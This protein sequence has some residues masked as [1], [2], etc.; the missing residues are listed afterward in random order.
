MDWCRGGVGG[1]GVL[2]H[3]PNVP[4]FSGLADAIYKIPREKKYKE[5]RTLGDARDGEAAGRWRRVDAG[6]QA[7]AHS[8]RRHFHG[9]VPMSICPSFTLATEMSVLSRSRESGDLAVGE[10]V[11]FGWRLG[12]PGMFCAAS[13]IMPAQTRGGAF[14]VRKQTEP[15]S[16]P[17]SVA[18]RLQTRSLISGCTWEAFSYDRRDR[19]RRTSAYLASRQ[20]SGHGQ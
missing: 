8:M 13:L 2:L 1:E 7:P 10:E 6:A 18:P 17:A 5:L 9:P 4:R 3:L 15:T 19:C 12:Q 16:F 20:S 14:S 11:G